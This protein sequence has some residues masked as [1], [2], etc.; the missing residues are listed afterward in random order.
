MRPY[1]ITL[2]LLMFGSTAEAQ[3]GKKVYISVKS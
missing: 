1:A 2:L 3:T